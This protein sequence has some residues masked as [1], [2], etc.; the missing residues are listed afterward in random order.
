MK[1]VKLLIPCL[2]LTLFCKAQNGTPVATPN[3]TT[4]QYYIYVL[5]TGVLPIDSKKLLTINDSSNI[6]IG[7]KQLF[8]DSMAGTWTLGTNDY[9]ANIDVTTGKLGKSK[10]T[11]L[12]MTKSQISDFPS[13]S[14]VATSGSYTDLS[15]KPT[16]PT[17]S[18]AS[19]SYSTT[20]TSN[21]LVTSGK[22]GE[23]QNA[24][25][26]SSGI[27]TFTFTNTYGANPNIQYNLGNGANNKESIV[28]TSVSTTSVSFLV[29][30]R[31]DVL[32]LLPSYAGVNGRNV[33]LSV[34][35]N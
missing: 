19:G 7:V 12:T 11:D 2:L 13:L 29:Q 8:L 15:N 20:I 18:G 10:W 34:V 16:I 33:Y 28:M 23:V 4:K 22:R 14:T 24:S 26:N 6:H 30:L 31:T 21:G 35:E 17:V 3:T 32:G 5:K 9:I 1:I 27:V 25:T